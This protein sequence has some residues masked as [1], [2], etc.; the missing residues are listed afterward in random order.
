[1][2]DLPD[3][4]KGAIQHSDISEKLIAEILDSNDSKEDKFAQITRQIRDA[5]VAGVEFNN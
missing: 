5:F 4:I 1:M 3:I 2:K